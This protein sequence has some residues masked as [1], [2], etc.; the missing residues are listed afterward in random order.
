MLVDDLYVAEPD[1]PE[2][3][4]CLDLPIARQRLQA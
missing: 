4:S 2:R 1:E 3:A